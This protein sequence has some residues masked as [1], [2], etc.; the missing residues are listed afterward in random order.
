MLWNLGRREDS[1]DWN[2]PIFVLVTW[3]WK[4]TS[5]WR[6]FSTNKHKKD[7]LVVKP[8]IIKKNSLHTM[9]V[10]QNAIYMRRIF[11]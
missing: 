7:K 3:S 5:K 1:E 11:E 9:L 8:Y 10:R 2:I 6:I 4:I